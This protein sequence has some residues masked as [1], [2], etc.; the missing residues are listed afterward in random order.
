MDWQILVF[1]LWYAT[2]IWLGWPDQVSWVIYSGSPLILRFQVGCLKSSVFAGEA[3]D[4]F[5]YLWYSFGNSKVCTT[6][7]SNFK[8]G[9]P[10]LKAGVYNLFDPW[11]APLNI[12]PSYLFYC[13][14]KQGIS[15]QPNIMI[16][17]YT[18]PPNCTNT[19]G[20]TTRVLLAGDERIQLTP[21][22]MHYR[23]LMHGVILRSAH[24]P[25]ILTRLNGI[26]S[27]LNAERRKGVFP[28]N[29]VRP[30][31]TWT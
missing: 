2:G 23:F 21:Q 29:L 16:C 6:S 8:K 26:L 22:S 19:V 25:D 27:R 7:S 11:L 17:A 24:H 10:Y 4:I 9:L 1:I 14:F 31:T 3:L 28:I 30:Y 5:L 13:Q 15:K 20:N 12:H 18:F